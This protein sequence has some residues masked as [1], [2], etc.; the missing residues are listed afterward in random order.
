MSAYASYILGNFSNLKSLPLDELLL[1]GSNQ[2]DIEH[3]I[4]SF[5]QNLLINLCTDAK[6][7]FEKED[8]ILEI[9]GDAI[10]VGDIHGNLHDLLRILNYAEKG[11]YKIIFLGDYVDRGCFS[12]ECVTLLFALKVTFPEKYFLLRGNHEFD[13]TCSQYGFKREILDH[14][15]PRK[16][17]KFEQKD[18]SAI[19]TPHKLNFEKEEKPVSAEKLCD[20]YFANHI[21]INC[22]KYTEELYE[23][24]LD[25]FS[26][27]PIASIVNK[28]SLCIHG[29]L[30]PHLDKI[31]KIRKNIHRPVTNYAENE[32]LCDILWGDPSP[33]QNQLFEYNPRGLGKLFNGVSVVTFLKSNNLQRLIRGHQCVANGIEK[34]FN[35]KCVT[36][37]S[38][39]SYDHDMR[40]K[41]G[42]LK[43]LKDDDKTESIRFKPIIPL[44]KCDATYFR[45]QSYNGE[46]SQGKSVCIKPVNSFN[47]LPIHCHIKHSNSAKESVFLA[48]HS[49]SDDNSIISKYQQRNITQL[50]RKPRSNSIGRA[51]LMGRS[52]ICLSPGAHHAMQCP[53]SPLVKP[54]VKS[55][56]FCSTNLDDLSVPNVMSL[57]TEE[58]NTLD[59]SCSEVRFPI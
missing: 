11:S 38:S 20:K 2:A 44:N 19:P 40:N 43:I 26:Y 32:L 50:V 30:S 15:D 5:D 37:F 31:E 52:P 24:F 1:L 17:Y 48:A 59:I 29:G 14:H 34:D 35:E 41:S 6:K 4:P 33:H 13:T 54:V 12:L 47:R 39:S 8:N 42:I 46:N 53:H 45:V 27:L 10:V 22:H 51:K 28:T 23:A 57:R 21:N 16:F 49:G 58:R 18:Y 3:P 25:A 36:V 9:D 7:E 55:P 56:Q